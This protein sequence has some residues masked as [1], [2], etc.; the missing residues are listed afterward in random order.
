MHIIRGHLHPANTECRIVPLRVERSTLAR[1]RWRGT[2]ED[3]VE[4]G[5]DLQFPLAEGDLFFEEAGLRY[6]IAQAPEQL[7]E[8]RVPEAE[9]AVRLGW[10]LGNL[11]F[12]IEI[13][14][15]LVRVVD[16]SAVRQLLEREGWPIVP[17]CEVFRPLGG[18]HHHS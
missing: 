9:T 12:P 6:V 11:H 4:F 17:V 18:A 3:G 8:I 5:F 16:D 15:T 2:A 7:L 14:G 1:R 13:Q 10:Q